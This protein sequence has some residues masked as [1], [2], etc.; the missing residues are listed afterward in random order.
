MNKSKTAK[1][2]PAAKSKSEIVES[3]APV[4]EPN[5]TTV[6]TPAIPAAAEAPEAKPASKARRFT[7]AE[8]VVEQN[9][10]KRPAADSLCGKVWA[11]LD[12]LKAD[13]KEPTAKNAAAALEGV[14]IAAATIRTQTQRW[15]VFAK[16]SAPAVISEEAQQQSA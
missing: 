7:K 12:Q 14:V 3:A 11:A 13:G 10:I 16:Q 4:A 15:K 9:G 5:L 8:G 6:D 1:S 2:K